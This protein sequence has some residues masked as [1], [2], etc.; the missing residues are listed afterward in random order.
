MPQSDEHF[1]IAIVGAGAVGSSLAYALAQAGFSVALIE[2][3]KVSAEQ[4]PA[5]D[6]R[7]LGFSRSTQVALQG[8]GFPILLLKN[9]VQFDFAAEPV[10]FRFKTI[11]L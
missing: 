7:H 5:F 6:E 11:K 2:K 1:D 9:R 4:Q 3:T 10:F 8:L